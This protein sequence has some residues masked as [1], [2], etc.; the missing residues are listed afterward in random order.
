MASAARKQDMPP[1]GGFKPLNFERVP[2]KTYFK[3]KVVCGT[4]YSFL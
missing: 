2:A 4:V 1:S 3:G